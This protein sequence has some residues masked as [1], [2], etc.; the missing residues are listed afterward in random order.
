MHVPFT[1]DLAVET[2]EGDWNVTNTHYII[3]KRLSLEII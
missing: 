3:S 1:C 2:V